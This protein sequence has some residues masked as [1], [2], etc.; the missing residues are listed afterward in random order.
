MKKV[1]KSVT[2]EAIVKIVVKKSL[3]WK[4]SWKKS[5][6]RIRYNENYHEGSRHKEFVTI[7]TIMKEVVKIETMEAIGK[8]IVRKN[9]LRWKP[10]WRK[11]SEK[12]R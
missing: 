4:P 1:V 11:S 8:K 2:K 7:E 6:K 12:N 10:S 3:P 5:S 9:S